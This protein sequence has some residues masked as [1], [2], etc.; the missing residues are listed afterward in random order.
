MVAEVSDDWFRILPTDP[1]F[2][3]STQVAARFVDE[4]RAIVP[5]AETIAV[6]GG[7]EIEF[8]DAGGNLEG[9]R[10]PRCGA[11]LASLEGGQWWQNRMTA[12]YEATHFADRR[13]D[14]P[15]CRAE[16]DLADLDYVWHT[17][18]ARWW[19]DCMNPARDRL[20]GEEVESLGLRLG[21][22]VHVVYRH[23]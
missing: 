20:S 1:A 17:G 18:F 3:P 4:V 23:S 21:I 12:S 6:V 7:D 8:V 5:D 10:C 16:S 11:D 22:A 14:L 15:C 2:A 19:A 9:V 13:L